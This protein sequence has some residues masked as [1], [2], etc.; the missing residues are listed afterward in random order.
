LQFTICCPSSIRGGQVTHHPPSIIYPRALSNIGHAYGLKGTK[1]NDSKK[2]V[3]NVKSTST[4][5]KWSDNDYEEEDHF[6]H[7]LYHNNDEK[8]VTCVSAKKIDSEDVDSEDVA[9]FKRLN[10]KIFHRRRGEQREKDEDDDRLEIANMKEVFEE[11][12]FF[13]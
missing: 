2:E 13:E 10:D 7:S 1:E 8:V 5:K 9:M 12:S 4:T 6:F 11:C 3:V